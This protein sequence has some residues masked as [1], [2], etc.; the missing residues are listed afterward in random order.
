[1]LS[2]NLE[3]TLYR[4]MELAN[5]YRHEFATLEHLLL[6]MTEDRDVLFVLEACGVD[7]TNLQKD[8]NDFIQNELDTIVAPKDKNPE[9]VPTAA[10]QRVIQRAAIHVQSAEREDEINAA[11]VLVAMFSEK[12]SFAVYILNNNGLAKLDVLNYLAH[13]LSSKSG[14]THSKVVSGTEKKPAL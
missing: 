3:K 8:L 7:I 2:E 14:K 10:F 9:T 4:A 11:H 12:D 6:A 5:I 13:G 1:M